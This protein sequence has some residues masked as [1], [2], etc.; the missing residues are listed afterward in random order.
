MTKDDRPDGSG[1]S[2]GLAG[3]SR[4]APTIEQLAKRRQTRSV[5]LGP[6]RRREA[7]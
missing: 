5:D 4:S 6:L 3:C 2:E 1:L 7:D